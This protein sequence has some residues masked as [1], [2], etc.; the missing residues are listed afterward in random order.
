[1]LYILLV[2][3]LGAHQEIFYHQNEVFDLNFVTC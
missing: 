1:M 3:I 2:D